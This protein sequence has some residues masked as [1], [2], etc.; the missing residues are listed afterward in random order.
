MVFLWF[1]GGAAQPVGIP[2]PRPPGVAVPLRHTPIS[3]F[4][5]HELFLVIISSWFTSKTSGR[6]IS[7]NLSDLHLL[8]HLLRLM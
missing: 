1:W 5:S 6:I 3:S 8:P 2:R 7:R 4:Y